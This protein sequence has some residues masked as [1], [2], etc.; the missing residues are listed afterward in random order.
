MAT[1]NGWSRA[2]WLALLPIGACS[3]I[4]GADFDGLEPHGVG[5]T[6]AGSAAGGTAGTGGLGGVGN[7][8]AGS[9]TPGG[10]AGGED[11]V[12]IAS[13]GMAGSD[14]GGGNAGEPAG[15][16]PSEGG[17]AGQGGSGNAGE[18]EAGAGGAGGAIASPTGV[19]INELKG[20]GAGAD[21]IELYNRGAETADIGGCYLTDDSSN[22]VNLPVGATIAPRGFVVVRL[23]QPAPTGM[24][25]TCFDFSPCYDGTWGIAASGEHIFLRDP[26][27]VLLDDLS[28]PDEMGPGNVGNGNSFGRIPDGAEITGAIR[29]SPG[30]T[31]LAVP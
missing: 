15:G 20:Q 31:N 28:Y 26:D 3:T 27:G 7:G 9:T 24:V 29:V 23:Q 16:S 8:T 14:P 1:V 21:F 25:T 11:G 5:G 4:V 6:S 12:T 22:R 13:G 2:V 18:S 17:A 30:A 19:V 10:G